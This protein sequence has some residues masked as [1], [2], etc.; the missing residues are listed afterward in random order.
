MMTSYINLPRPARMMYRSSGGHGGD[1]VVGG[2][3]GVGLAGHDPGGLGVEGGRA[4]YV[5]DAVTERGQGDRLDLGAGAAPAAAAQLAGAGEPVG[6]VVDRGEH[7]VDPLALGC[8][9]TQDRGTPR[10]GLGVPAAEGEHVPQ[11]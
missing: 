9:G 7:L 3:V 1:Q 2:G 5:A 11:V 6:V 10:A 4:V 8:D